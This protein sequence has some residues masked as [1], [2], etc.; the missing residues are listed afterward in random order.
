MKRG[1]R[2]RGGDYVKEGDYV[3][4]DN[5]PQFKGFATIIEAN[6]ANDSA[7]NHI[8]FDLTIKPVDSNKI[9]KL[10]TSIPIEYIKKSNKPNET[11]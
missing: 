5:F 6:E 9:I 1:R 7:D 10:G 4:I 8:M 2:Q 3:Y 11:L